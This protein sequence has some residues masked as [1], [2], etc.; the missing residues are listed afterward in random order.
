VAAR[1]AVNDHLNYVE[2]ALADQQKADRNEAIAKQ[3]Y[4]HEQSR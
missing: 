1:A 3:R 2:K 4:E